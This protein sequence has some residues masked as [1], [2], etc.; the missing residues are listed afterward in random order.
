MTV[1][2]ACNKYGCQR[3][4]CI[5][6]PKHNQ[7]QLLLNMLSSNMCQIQICPPNWAYIHYVPYMYA[8]YVCTYEVTGTNHSRGCTIHILDIYHCGCNIP[9]IAHMTNMLNRHMKPTFLHISAKTHPA[10]TSSH[11]LL[12]NMCQI[13]TCP[14]N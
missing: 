4:F 9:N 5:Y 8:I 14:P 2:D 10:A 7:H 13:Q 11:M 3:H 6:L 12:P 1:D